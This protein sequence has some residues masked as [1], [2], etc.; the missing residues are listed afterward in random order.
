M[1]GV[2][3]DTH[4]V[5]KSLVGSHSYVIKRDGSRAPVRFDEILNRIQEQADREPKL[6]YADVATVAQQVVR[7]IIP[8]IRTADLDTLSART[9]SSMCVDHPDYGVLAGRI[10][11]ADL[12]KVTPL[13]FSEA[14]RQC[15]AN[16]HPINPTERASLI[17]EKGMDFVNKHAETIDSFINHEED[18]NYDIFAVQTLFR[19]YLL[20][21]GDGRVVE[22]PQYMLMRSALETSG[23]DF[24]LEFALVT[25]QRLSRREFTFATPCLYNSLTRRPQLASCFLMTVEDSIESIYKKLSD[26]AILSK[27][28]GGIGFSI[29]DIR[30]A[31]S[32]IAGTGGISN[33]IVPMLRNFNETARYVD[34]CFHPSTLIYTEDGPLPIEQIVPGK[35]RAETVDGSFQYVHEKRSYHVD[36]STLLALRYATTTA[37]VHVTAEHPI[38]V[39]RWPDDNLHGQYTPDDWSQA[40]MYDSRGLGPVIDWQEVGECI[41]G[42]MVAVC[43]IKPFVAS[44]LATIHPSVFDHYFDLGLLYTRMN[45]SQRAS[46]LSELMTVTE[47]ERVR[48]FFLGYV[49]SYYPGME[50]DSFEAKL[51]FFTCQDQGNDNCVQHPPHSPNT[52]RLPLSHPISDKE[53]VLDEAPLQ[54]LLRRLNQVMVFVDGSILMDAIIHNHVD[55]FSSY[56]TQHGA[57]SIQGHVVQYK[58]YLWTPVVSLLRA[59]TAAVTNQ[60]AA[61]TEVI[62]LDMHINHNYVLDGG[63]IAH[64]GG[65]KRKG[66]FAAYLEPWHADIYEFLELKKNHGSE[67]KRARDLFYALWIPDLFMKRVESDGMWSLFCPNECRGLADVYGSEFE[68]LY[69]SFEKAGKFRKQVPAKD[70]M[71]KITSLQIETGVPYMLYKDAINRK[72]NQS[73][74]GTIRSSNLCAEITLFTAEDETAV[75]NLASISLKAFVIRDSAGK[76]MFD[77]QKLHDSTYHLARCVDNTIDANFY[78][79]PSTEKS[80]L[81]HR[82]I[83]IGIQGLQELFYELRLP[84]DSPEACRLQEDVLETMYHAA[85]SSSCDTSK[86]KGSYSTF[87]G[88]PASRG[89]LQFD[90]WGEK[91]KSNRYDWDALKADIVQYGLRNSQLISLMPTASTSSLLRNTECFEPSS[92]N[93]MQRETLAGNHQVVNEYL[94]AD[95]V[96]INQWTSEVRNRMIADNGSIQNIA[97]LPTELKNLYKTCWEISN[98]VIMDMAAARGKYICQSNSMN[99]FLANATQSKISSMHM[100]GWKRGLKTGCYYMRTRAATDPT[101][102][103]VDPATMAQSRLDRDS[104]MKNSG[105]ILLNRSG[106]SSS[107]M[108]S[109]ASSTALHLSA[110]SDFVQPNSPIVDTSDLLMEEGEAGNS[111][112][113]ADEICDSCG[114]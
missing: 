2:A 56:R 17:S 43:P 57:W 16:T 31:K 91:P 99:L 39:C 52:W 26:C 11:I 71:N 98:R 95:L 68:E 61:Q 75:C 109:L 35:T 51:D 82:P 90:L 7:G 64:N 45:Y 114:A 113:N 79:L 74:L 27:H 23:I 87:Q 36:S 58:E 85:L 28:A 9:A 37:T 107:P 70:L 42:T 12:H 60:E 46:A 84:F 49:M 59:S 32:Y 55:K 19:A 66:S 1:S 40:D 24:D 3:L 96:A 21:L 14:M 34:Q 30:A 6:Q 108:S 33:G 76:K 25:Y 20:K 78:P 10:R 54:R 112:P 97:Q 73:N 8:G 83:G 15:Y 88:S 18:Y 53:H 38:L 41:A 80:N 81:R 65:G 29:H 104:L 72:S 22:R 100:Y 106:S 111:S 48:A 92:G 69:E 93:I 94:I 63:L 47:L 4:A 102:F 13:T 62:D 50:S 67:A 44:Q 103:T 77:H 86:R 89:L 110:S 105:N 5:S 101:K